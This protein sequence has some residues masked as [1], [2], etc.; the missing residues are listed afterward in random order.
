MNWL[1]IN[2]AP[3]DG[4]L[5]LLHDNRDPDNRPYV[6]RWG[7]PTSFRG[8]VRDSDGVGVFYPTQFAFLPHWDLNERH[9][10]KLSA[11]PNSGM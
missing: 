4:T 7:G 9:N 5:V 8:W 1:M 3:K 11:A 6:G 2:E 10:R